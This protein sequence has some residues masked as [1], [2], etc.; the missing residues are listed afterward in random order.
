MLATLTEP[1]QASSLILGRTDDDDGASLRFKFTAIV[2][3]WNVDGN[4]WPHAMFSVDFEQRYT[5]ITLSSMKWFRMRQIA[6]LFSSSVLH[7]RA[8]GGGEPFV[9]VVV[10]ERGK[11][12]MGN[13]IGGKRGA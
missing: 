6:H 4:A 9:Q 3:H 10:V 2:F 13:T 11:E 5:T 7:S 12:R 8:V 1:R